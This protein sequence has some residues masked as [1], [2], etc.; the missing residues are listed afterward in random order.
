MSENSEKDKDT[1][2]QSP[3][4]DMTTAAFPI[5][6]NAPIGSGTFTKINLAGPGEIGTADQQGLYAALYRSPED[7]KNREDKRTLFLGEDALR[8]RGV[9]F[10]GGP[11]G[12]NYFYGQAL[13]DENGVIQRV[14]YNE[15]DLNTEAQTVL[16]NMTSEMRK[17]WAREAKRVGFY[18]NN[19]PSPIILSRGDAFN[20]TDVNAMELFLFSANRKNQ[21][22]SAFLQTVGGFASVQT[23]TTRVAPVVSSPEDIGYYLNQTS[24]SMTGKPMTKAIAK[25]LIEQYQKMERE[26]ATS[27]VSAPSKSVF[28]ESAVKKRLPEETAGYAVGKAIQLAFQALAGR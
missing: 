25:Q 23:G 24:L 15:D 20:S 10:G 28:A 9:P 26:A 5:S 3:T 11:L 12:Q 13:L 22:A 16:G 21:T 2:Q 14:S 27:R 18:G 1:S 7:I 8:K 19:N 17:Q 6:L 4:T